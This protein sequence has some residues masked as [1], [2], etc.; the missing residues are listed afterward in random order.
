MWCDMMDLFDP[1][2]RMLIQADFD[3]NS[4]HRYTD[5]FKGVIKQTILKQEVIFRTQVHE[6]HQLYKT[7]KTL[8]RD[9]G[10]KGCGGYNSWDANVQP[11]SPPFPNP[12]R[13]EPLVKETGISSI[14]KVGSAP[15]AN[16]LL[17]G[18]QEAYY[19]LKQRPLD[20]QLSA[21]EFINHVEEGSPNR[22]HAWN[23]LSANY[24][25]GTEELKLSLN[26]RDD[27]RRTEDTLRTWFD[28]RTHQYCS[29]IDL[30]SEE[31]ISDDSVKCTPFVGFAT[32]ETCSPGKYK[33][34][35]SAF[36]SLIFSTGAEKNPPVDISE[37][38][39]FQE[40]SECCQEQTSSNEGIMECRDDNLCNNL[41]TKMQQSSS[42]KGADLDLNKA[43]F[44]VSSCFSNDPL[45]AC[46]SPPRSAG[47]SAVVTRSMQEETCP[48]T[49]WEKQ[50]NSCSNEISDMLAENNFINATEVDLNST[51]R[52]TDVW[53]VNS[54]PDGMSGTVPNPTGPEPI[55]CSPADISE[56]LDRYT[57]DHKNDN[58][59]MKAKLTN[60]LLHDL[61][62]LPTDTRELSFEKSQVEDAV[63]SCIDQCQ[64]DGHGNQSPVSCKSG[65]Y[66]NDSNSGKTVHFGSTS[67]DVN[68][69]L[70]TLLGSQVADASSDEHDLRTSDSGDL[71]NECDDKT[72]ESAKVDVLMKRAAESL[73]DMSLKNLVCYQDSFAKE[74][75][76]EMRNET[77]EQPQYTCD[78]F[79]LM[80]MDLTESN[81][82]ENSVTSKPYE[83]NDM[84]TKDFGSKLRRG[85]RMKD[86]Q[87]E[88][89]PA[90]ASLSR[91]EIHEDINI[92]EGVLRSRE[93][94]K[95]RGKMATN[96]ENWS[97]LVR[98]RRSR[99][100]HVGRRS[101]LMK[102]N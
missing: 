77:R 69:D 90:L 19:R 40:H 98:S 42:H 52:S 83:V 11:S 74:G 14:S 89:L 35:V 27:K 59:V 72:E 6:L 38:N 67:D 54:E 7:Q 71:K 79:E 95:I 63:F 61:N 57:G 96:G 39:S 68:T 20:L 100:N 2:K 53:T 34:K 76:K 84:E 97:P 16:E 102:F 18:R 10:G 91:H 33:S 101:C 36:S 92:I 3:L 99:L 23:P 58:V 66:D 78:S 4:V 93:Y 1:G 49:V 24:S 13:I 43:H 30:E 12:S 45:V 70:K 28:K 22:G 51:T 60:C 31:R 47:V 46:P 81:V 32:P 29:V 26:A 88:I 5:S 75:S 62:Q 87:K 44:D 15:F 21:N 86:F 94:R 8:M 48:T 64:N 50:V 85:R 55:P 41:S 37:S 65:I 25:S 73:L 82:E 9:H 80:V 17:H 56:D